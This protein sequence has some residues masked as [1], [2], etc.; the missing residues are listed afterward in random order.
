MVMFAFLPLT[1]RRF[2]QPTSFALIYPKP[3][4]ASDTQLSSSRSSEELR[5]IFVE[6]GITSE[7]KLA[8]AI[9][10]CSDCGDISISR[11]RAALKQLK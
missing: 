11:V 6:T 10:S 1:S 2:L 8:E 7:A 9:K 5:Q 3:V 4:L